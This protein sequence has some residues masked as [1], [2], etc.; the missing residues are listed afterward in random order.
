MDGGYSLE[1]PKAVAAQIFRMPVVSKLDADE[2]AECFEV[3]SALGGVRICNDR[4]V[5]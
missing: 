5:L 3:S 2:L 4:K 1:P